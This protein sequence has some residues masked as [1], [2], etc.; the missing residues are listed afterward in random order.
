MRDGER[1]MIMSCVG[2]IFW[3]AASIAALVGS[4]GS[5]HALEKET[6]PLTFS[7]QWAHDV[8][9]RNKVKGDVVNAS[10]TF[11]F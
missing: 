9:E 5:V 4:G 2:R 3:L 8:G 10:A 6:A 11:V 1:T 7:A